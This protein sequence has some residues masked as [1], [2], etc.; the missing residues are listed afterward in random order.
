MKWLIPIGLVILLPLAHSA[1]ANEN[2]KT[3]Q[4]S[5]S[6]TFYE[7][8]QEESLQK[9]GFQVVTD[10]T[11]PAQVPARLNALVELDKHSDEL[12]KEDGAFMA[13]AKTTAILTF[14]G[15]SL[16]SA[17]STGAVVGSAFFARGIAAGAAIGAAGGPIAPVTIAIAAGV[18]AVIGF[19]L[20]VTVV[21]I[22]GDNHEMTFEV[23]PMGKFR[24]HV[25]PV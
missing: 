23:D 10:F 15:A 1:F 9:T 20:G 22:S 24:F 16:A 12:V 3:L 11:H 18:G 14:V 25:K 17:A 8:L 6:E 4:F 5:D 13:G 21:I 2:V 7:Q 19:T